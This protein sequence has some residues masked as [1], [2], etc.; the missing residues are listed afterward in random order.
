MNDTR[1][2]LREF[3]EYWVRPDTRAILDTNA[4][5]NQQTLRASKPVTGKARERRHS[6]P[7]SS[8]RNTAGGRLRSSRRACL[9]ASVDSVVGA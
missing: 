7:M 4:V 8:E 2:F 6:G 3:N 5:T 1:T 9:S